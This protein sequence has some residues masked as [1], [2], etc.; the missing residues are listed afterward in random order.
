MLQRQHNA[1]PGERE[2]NKGI[3]IARLANLPFTD[4]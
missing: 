3:N 2:E 4:D 1:L